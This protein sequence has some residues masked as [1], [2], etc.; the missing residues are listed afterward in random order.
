[1]CWRLP[2]LRFPSRLMGAAWGGK[3]A[4]WWWGLF[5]GFFESSTSPG[6]EAELEDP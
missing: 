5:W 3:L 6:N 1:M 4:I 2:M